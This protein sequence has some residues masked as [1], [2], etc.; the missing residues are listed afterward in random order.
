[1]F[2]SMFSSI[3]T[4][5]MIAIGLCC[6][7]LVHGTASAQGD[8]AADPGVLRLPIY[9]GLS[10]EPIRGQTRIEGARA[11][12][13]LPPALQGDVVQHD[14]L[15]PNP[16]PA[17]L[18]L[19]NVEACS[20]CVLDGYSREIPPGGVGRI[21]I[22]VLTD[23]RGGDTVAG[24]VTA[25]TSDPERPRI[26]VALEIEIREFARIDPYRIWL[27]GRVG[28]PIVATCDVTANADHPFDITGIKTRKGV[29]F[30]LAY[31]RVEGADPAAWRITLTNTRTKPGPY[32]DILFV[33][34]DHP[35]RPEF[36]I[37][38]EG[39]IEPAD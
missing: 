21:S 17:A 1:M 29:W 9:H 31:A 22:V 35:E 14:L 34:T 19:S 5:R 25:E 27:A 7:S 33:Q 12:V 28:E 15:V 36:K 26:E 11:E 20:G 4:S 38:V 16:G 10:S 13:R 37:R 32:Q 30:D 3:A 24:T 39:R 2:S 6:A 23:S 8:A 18:R